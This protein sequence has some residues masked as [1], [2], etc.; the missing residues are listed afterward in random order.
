M[1]SLIRDRPA[2]TA[3][4]LAVFGDEALLDAAL[5]FEAGLAQAQAQV[6]VI[7]PASAARIAAACCAANSARCASSTSRKLATP[8]R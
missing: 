5:R 1:P 6:G 8:L 7:D 3:A 4:M 2:S